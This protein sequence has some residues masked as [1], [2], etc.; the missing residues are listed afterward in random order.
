MTSHATYSKRPRTIDQIIAEEGIYSMMSIHEVCAALGY[1]HQTKQGAYQAMRA[2]G[3]PKELLDARVKV[4]REYKF[5]T[6][7]VLR[8]LGVDVPSPTEALPR[9]V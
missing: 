4:A 6:P 3:F 5:P 7:K 9:A 2:P 8:Y 1:K